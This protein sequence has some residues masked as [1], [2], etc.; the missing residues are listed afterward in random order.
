MRT[1][2]LVVLTH[3]EGGLRATDDSNEGLD[4]VYYL[5][6][7]DILTPYNWVKRGEHFWKSLSQDKDRISAIPPQPYGDR[8]LNFMRCVLSSSWLLS[9]QV[10]HSRRRSVNA[11]Q[12]ASIFARCLTHADGVIL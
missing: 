4:V 6:I 1:P 12:S 10:C 8:F 7:I 9:G 2:L 3:A 5:G 11:S